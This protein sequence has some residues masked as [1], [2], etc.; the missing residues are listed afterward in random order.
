MDNLLTNMIDKV[1][2]LRDTR[3]EFKKDGYGRQF[4][5]AGYDPVQ[6][7]MVPKFNTKSLQSIVDCRGSAII[8]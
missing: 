6:P 4:T 8:V 1:L 5:L 3:E 2:S 7:S